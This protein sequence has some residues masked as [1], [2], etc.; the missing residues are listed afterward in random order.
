MNNRIRFSKDLEKACGRAIENGL[1]L[2]CSG[3]D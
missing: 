1:E 2:I 3:E